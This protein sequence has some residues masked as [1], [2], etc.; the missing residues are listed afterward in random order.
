MDLLDKVLI[1]SK[2]DWVDHVKTTC[3]LVRALVKLQNKG[4]QLY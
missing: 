3:E 2:K 4:M 1:K